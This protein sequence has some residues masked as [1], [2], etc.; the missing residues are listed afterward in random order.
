MSWLI[1]TFRSSIGKKLLMAVTGLSFICFLASH[2]AGNLTLYAGGAAFNAYAEK[3]HSMGP[4]LTFFELGLLV[5]ALI[6]VI[7]G[8]TLYVQN[9]KARS[10]PY[11]KDEAAGGR[12]LS[13]RTM[14]YTGFIILGFVALLLSG[15]GGLLGGLVAYR[16]SGGKINPLI[17]IAGVS[18]L[19][20]TA[21][22]AHKCAQEA[23]PNVFIL[24]YAMG[25]CIAG[26]ITTAIITAC[27]ITRTP[28]LPF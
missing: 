28:N 19:P 9:Y 4:I 21:K 11:K 23:D 3:L 8:I 17:G 24:P 26:V 14:P 15:V 2:L 13:S 1:Q 25:P 18:C 27:Y 10:V 5:L 16:V 12:T 6:H 7:T 20:T 22:V